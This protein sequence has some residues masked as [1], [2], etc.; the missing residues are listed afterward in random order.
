MSG[1]IGKIKTVRAINMEMGRVCEGRDIPALKKEVR[2]WITEEQLDPKAVIIEEIE[3]HDRL[4]WGFII[5]GK[6][7]V[8]G[9]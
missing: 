8:V 1:E 3:T 6:K 9:R 5:D 4:Q 2:R 7:V